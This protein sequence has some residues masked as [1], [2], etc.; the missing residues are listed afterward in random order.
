A[1][2]L[3]SRARLLARGGV[4]MALAR[5]RGGV[6]PADPRWAYGGED[7]DGDGI[8][9]GTGYERTEQTYE[10]TR[11]NV[12]DCPAEYALRPSF[13]VITGAFFAGPVRAPDLVW[14]DGRLRG[15]S[16]RL[17]GTAP[18][19]SAHYVLKVEDAGVKIDLNLPDAPVVSGRGR[20]ARLLDNL[21]LAL[22]A[23]GIPDPVA[24][25]GAAVVAYR[26]SRP[27]G[28]FSLLEDLQ[29][30]GLSIMEVERLRSYVAVGNPSDPTTV[31]PRFSS[32]SLAG[33]DPQPRAAVSLQGAA[34][35]VLASLL[36]LAGDA[37]RAVDITQAEMQ[38]GFGS[39]QIPMPRATPRLT[40]VRATVLADAL[41]AR[42]AADPFDTWEEFRTWLETL[43][44][45]I[46][47]DE[48]ALVSANADPNTRL[49]K[50][51][52]D[53]AMMRRLDKTDV[54]EPTTEF[55]LGGSGAASV[56]SVGRVLG[57]QGTL[58]ARA[59]CEVSLRVFET[60]HDSTQAQ[61]AAA[62]AALPGAL[63]GV[64]GDDASGAR[65]ARGAAERVGRAGGPGARPGH[66]RDRLAHTPG[67]AADRA[68]GCRR[69]PPVERVGPRG[70]GVRAVPVRPL[71]DGGP[72]LPQR[73]D[74]RRRSVHLAE[75]SPRPRFGG[76]LGQLGGV[77]FRRTL[78]LDLCGA[79]DDGNV[80]EAGLGP[81][82]CHSQR[83]VAHVG[84]PVQHH[85]RHVQQHP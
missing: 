41:I 81:V 19:A 58:L 77:P 44:T 61:F 4:E 33:L 34:R 6:D 24:G 55:S 2:V 21:G 37:E 79:R 42:R 43:P 71:R 78:Q 5:L 20:L 38:M 16:G 82:R 69:R 17:R 51:N 36:T 63:S 12:G 74:P 45:G 18:G 65:R 84:S 15:F 29:G 85:V 53:A 28:R 23:Q 59:G 8:W 25:R 26:V 14:V 52:P 30:A 67:R 62:E 54:T 32:G 22:A 72:L 13:A 11:L 75:A 60:R 10:T 49:N 80:G 56:G 57:P 68:R 64:R 35:P 27:G 73:R 83:S 48:A 39:Y 9:A 70:A 3:Q 40:L 66:S 31:S 1:V 50:F 7:W 46:T 76:G 47:R